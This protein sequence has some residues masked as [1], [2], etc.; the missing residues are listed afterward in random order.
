MPWCPKCKTEY[1]DGVSKCA[2]CGSTLT[3]NPPIEP[4]QI[5]GEYVEDEAV[6]MASTDDTVTSKMFEARLQ[7][8]GIPFLV[9]PHAGNGYIGPVVGYSV[10]GDDI[11]VP[12]K[13]LERALEAVG[14][15]GEELDTKSENSASL[16]EELEQQLP[17]NI[18]EDIV[19]K[20]TGI[21]E[22]IKNVA[23]LLAIVLVLM[24][25]FA[26]NALLEFLR[27]LFGY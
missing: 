25:Y 13:L 18:T 9:K 4:E 3:N 2:D 7:S 10:Y 12:L 15:E 23:V 5:R 8:A 27:K 6:F 22:I 1:I 11:F 14:L 20:P 21:K 26:F 19:Q 17:D 16:K 24:G